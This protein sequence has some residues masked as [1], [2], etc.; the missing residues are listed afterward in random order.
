MG[1]LI[2]LALIGVPYR[3]TELRKALTRNLLICGLSGILVPVVAIKV[4]D[5]VV[6]LLPGF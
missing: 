4:I 5:L 6:S 3:T 1:I 2:P